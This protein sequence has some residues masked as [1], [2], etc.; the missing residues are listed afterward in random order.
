MDN[1]VDPGQ[2]YRNILSCFGILVSEFLLTYC[3]ELIDEVSVWGGNGGRDSLT[4]TFYMGHMYNPI[5]QPPHASHVPYACDAS[6]ACTLQLA[7]PVLLLRLI[8]KGY[9]L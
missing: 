2:G 9:D 7:L 8:G 5:T 3:D 4:T 6:P 1:G